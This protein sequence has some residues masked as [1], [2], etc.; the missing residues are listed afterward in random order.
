MSFFCPFFKAKSER[1]L[2]FKSSHSKLILIP[3]LISVS[4][5]CARPPG[6]QHGDLLNQTEANRG[7]FPPGTLLTYGCEPGYTADGPT[8]IICTS[9]GSW[10][11][12]PPHCIRSN[13]EQGKKIHLCDK[14]QKEQTVVNPEKK[15]KYILKKWIVW[16]KAFRS[17]L[18]CRPDASG[19]AEMISAYKNPLL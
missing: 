4:S 10:S 6:V 16:F 9:S 17:W 18:K 12:Q 8:S 14:A 5:G 3:S 2:S 7:S 13:G 1:L 11:H 19:W 15:L